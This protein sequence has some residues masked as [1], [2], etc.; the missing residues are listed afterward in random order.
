MNKENVYVYNRI[1]LRHDKEWNNAI[2]NDR[3]GP[4]NYTKYNKP[5]TESAISYH[6]YVEFKKMIEINFN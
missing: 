6:L 1:V 2:F 5:E 4:R 3:D